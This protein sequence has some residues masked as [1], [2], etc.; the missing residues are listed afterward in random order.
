MMVNE[1]HARPILHLSR[2]AALSCLLRCSPPPRW[3][4]FVLV[5]FSAPRAVLYRLYM[6]ARAVWELS[7]AL[8]LHA[9]V[10]AHPLHRALLCRLAP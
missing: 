10:F 1:L 9:T 2:H 4:C 5:P 8:L 7:C 3:S 6:H